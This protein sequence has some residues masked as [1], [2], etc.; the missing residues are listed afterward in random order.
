M[1]RS[2]LVLLA[3]VLEEVAGQVIAEL[4]LR[5]DGRAVLTP[6]VQQ[7]LRSWLAQT[8]AQV[9]AVERGVEEEDPG[10]KRVREIILGRVEDAGTIRTEA[11]EHDAQRERQMVDRG[12]GVE[13][14][15]ICRERRALPAIDGLLR[16]GLRTTPR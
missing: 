11:S 15:H 12:L 10:R 1:N 9:V 5:R 4:A 3:V 14:F 2:V 16:P 8:V 13:F 6:G 7:R